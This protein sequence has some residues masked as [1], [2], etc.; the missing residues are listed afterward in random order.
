MGK[1]KD[2]KFLSSFG[3]AFEL[4]MSI[5]E[6]VQNAGGSDKELNL[7]RGNPERLEEVAR[8][9]MGEY[10]S[11]IRLV[12]RVDY[13]QPSKSELGDRLDLNEQ[14]GDHDFLC[15]TSEACAGVSREARNVEFVLVRLLAPYDERTSSENALQEIARRKLRPAMYEEH[16]AFV[17]TFKR[18][19]DS[20]R[21]VAL[22][23]FTEHPKDGVL[24]P[25]TWHD[26]S[27]S[28]LEYLTEWE[29]DTLFLAV[30]E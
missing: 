23:S 18:V 4:F 2:S 28:F 9:V 6:A 3:I 1:K 26:D 12:T 27:V 20:L 30:R 22:G 21:V 29:N 16:L 8:A 5:V 7:L 14:D 17:S 24:V 11:P 10:T 19:D 13:R 15:K 25:C